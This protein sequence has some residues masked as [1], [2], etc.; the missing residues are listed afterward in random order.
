[1]L[2]NKFE[3]TWRI[4]EIGKMRIIKETAVGFQNVEENLFSVK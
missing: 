4:R 2:I 1:M 3:N